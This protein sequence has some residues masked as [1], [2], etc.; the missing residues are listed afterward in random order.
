M[1]EPVTYYSRDGKDYAVFPLDIDELEALVG[2][3][4]VCDR[5]RADYVEALAHLAGRRE[6]QMRVDAIY[7]EEDPDAIQP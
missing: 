5:M 2:Y 1:P 6:R 7:N 3:I 4:P